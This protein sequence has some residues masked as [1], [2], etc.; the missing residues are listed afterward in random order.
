MSS[1]WDS[2]RWL[3][4]FYDDNDFY[5]RRSLL[6]D[7]FQNTISLVQDQKYTCEDG[8]VVDLPLDQ[9]L[10]DNTVFYDSL[11]AYSKPE[12]LFDTKISVIDEDVMTVVQN[13]QSQGERPLLLNMANR[14]NPGGNVVQGARAQE[15]TLFRSS[16]Y[17]LSLF[18]FAYYSKEYNLPQRRNSYPLAMDYGAVFSPGVTFFRGGIDT[19]FALFN[20]P[21]KVDLIAVPAFNRPEL[22]LKGG[23]YWLKDKGQIEAITN[24]IR[25]ILR[26]AIVN[27]FTTLILSA[28]GC[29]AFKNPPN[30]VAKIFAQ[31]FEEKEF[32][33]AFDKIIFAIKNDHN[34]GKQHN[35]KGNY[36]PFAEIFK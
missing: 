13:L 12:K 30:H 1:S 29:G 3:E 22:F 15:E 34:S 17:F 5:N 18:Q 19:G 32:K 8:T 28:F 4:Q 11:F 27:G 23:L 24:K 33:G 7:V 10:I 16:N 31:V 21:F 20:K 14:Y 6:S 26:V 35:P 9:E 36:A 25:T 2:K